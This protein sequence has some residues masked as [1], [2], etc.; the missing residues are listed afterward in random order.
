MKEIDLEDLKLQLVDS[1]RILAGKK[2]VR[3]ITGHVSARIP[4]TDEMLIRCRPPQDPG[5]EFTT[6]NDIKRVGFD[7]SSSELGGGYKL[8]GEFSIHAE[9]Y[10]ARADVGSVV[11]GHPHSS[12]MC[13]VLGL[14]FRAVI[15]AYDPGALE[16]A[17][18][19]VPVFPRAVL[20]TTPELGRQVVGL[21]GQSNVCLL[22][23]H[24]IVAAGVDV[25]DATVRAVKFETMAQITME[26]HT[27]T[28]EPFELS[29]DDI[30]ETMSMWTPQAS[31][32]VQW[33]WDF[34][35]RS[36]DIKSK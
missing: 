34:Y 24:G 36:L 2:C 10:K 25:A 35:R 6:V 8:P 27:T 21:M 28:R 14:S 22:R 9:I 15:G 5:V 16:I 30:A 33:T 11:H 4:G 31:T 1:C 17:L 3:E 7:G 32:L 20:I 19:K 13:G 29:D 23:G 18:S 12:L 26:I